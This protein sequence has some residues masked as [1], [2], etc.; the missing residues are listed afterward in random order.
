LV[1]DLSN[2]HPVNKIDVATRLAN[3]ALSENY[4]KSGLT[5][6]F[7]MF[8]A[9][10]NEKNK[11]RILFDNADNG[12]IA[13]DK[14]IKELFIAGEDRQ[15]LPAMAKIEGNAL[16]VWNKTIKAPVAVRFGFSNT[17][18]PNLFSKEG[19]PVNLFRTDNW[20]VD[21]KPMKK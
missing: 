11:I 17:A 9:M 20:E 4:G 19:L 15:F 12:L 18:T 2:I 10:K 21:T 14:T 6:K 7:P 13:K 16:I 8:K 5:Y 1:D 3:T